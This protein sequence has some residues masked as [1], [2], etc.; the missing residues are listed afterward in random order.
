MKLHVLRVASKIVFISLLVLFGSRPLSSQSIS[1]VNQSQTN[2]HSSEAVPTISYCELM[3]NP[4][5]YVGQMVR[6]SATWDAGFEW[7]YLYHRDCIAH[8]NEAHVDFVEEENSCPQTKKNL[9]KINRKYVNSKGDV[10]VVGKLRASGSYGHMGALSRE[11]V[12]TCLE[13]YKAISPNIP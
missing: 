4:D 5:K 7:S 8:R 9:K 6:V 11:F 12:I 2:S 3:Q 10:V 13:S 1:T